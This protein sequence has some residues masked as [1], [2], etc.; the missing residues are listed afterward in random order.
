[1]ENSEKHPMQKLKDELMNILNVIPEGSKI[2]YLDYPVHG[3]IGDLLIYKG[4]EQFFSDN[5]I[6]IM[7]QYSYHSFPG[8]LSIPTDH[9]IVCHGGGNLGDLYL[10]H[11][12][13]REKIV[14]QYPN[15]RIV[16]LPQTVYFEQRNREEQARKIFNQH[17]HLYIFVR[18]KKSLSRLVGFTSKKFVSPDMA[19]QLWP[20]QVKRSPLKKTLYLL[21]KDKEKNNALR[22]D[23]SQ[24][25]MDWSTLLSEAEKSSIKKMISDH[26]NKSPAAAQSW[27][28][29]KNNL[30]EKAVSVYSQYDEITTSRLHGH[31]LACL[32]NKKNTLLD[33]SYGKNSAY[34]QTWTKLIS[35]ARFKDKN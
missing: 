9:I 27:S 28:L 1:M 31:I 10:P 7:G 8:K 24:D 29:L 18:D 5:K 16:I 26:N 14:E 17:R 19:H 21:R 4:T 13:F 30:I 23:N 25:I 20:I 35:T 15:H 34:F 3:N 32:M 6:K 2:H 22:L 33:N 11:Q 12:N